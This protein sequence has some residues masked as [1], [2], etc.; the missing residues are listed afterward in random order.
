[1]VNLKI[2]NRDIEVLENEINL[3]YKRDGKFNSPVDPHSNCY[4]GILILFLV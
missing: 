3:N 2:I 1:M 4:I